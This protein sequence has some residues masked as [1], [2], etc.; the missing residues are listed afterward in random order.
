MKAL[1]Q[2]KI[3]VFIA[4]LTI[5]FFLSCKSGDQQQK[6]LDMIK[7]RTMGLAYIEGK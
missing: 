6:A 7:A 2:L 3:S 5:S 4:F 1:K